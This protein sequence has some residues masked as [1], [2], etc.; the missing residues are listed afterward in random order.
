[1]ALGYC[2]L[3]GDMSGGLSVIADVD[4]LKVYEMAKYRNSISK[5]IPTNSI[6]KAPSAELK[7]NQTDEKGLGASYEILVPLV[8][9]IIE[10]GKNKEE[11]IRNYDETLVDNTLRRIHMSEYKRRQAAPAFKVTKKSFGIGRRVPMIHNFF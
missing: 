3:Y 11:L 9:E 5:V 10:E 8:N 4:K 1:M 7:P 2:T 6:E